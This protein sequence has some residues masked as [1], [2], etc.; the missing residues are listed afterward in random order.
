MFALDLVHVGS[1]LSA[2]PEKETHGTANPGRQPRP[3]E[4][5]ADFAGGFGLRR[6]GL[7]RPGNLSQPQPVGHRLGDLADEVTLNLSQS[8]ER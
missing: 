1:I 4:D 6:I 5:V 2:Q 8:Q 3:V 7:N